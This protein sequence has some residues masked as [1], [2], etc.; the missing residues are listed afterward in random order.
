MFRASRIPPHIGI[1]TDG[2]LYDITSVGPNIDL[3]VKD[4][5]K[6]ILKRK[7]EVLFIELEKPVGI[8]L[9]QKITEKVREHWKVTV[10]TSCLSPIKD[11]I[12][13]VYE[14]DVNDVKFI[15]ELLPILFERNLIKDVSQLNLSNKIINNC[16]ELTKYTEKDIENCIEALSRKE[17]ITC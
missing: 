13:D 2:K 10:D 6:T 5:Y 9:S 3:P 17:K 7:T 14:V 8:D 15:F 11:F 12:N 4:F 1:V 16:L